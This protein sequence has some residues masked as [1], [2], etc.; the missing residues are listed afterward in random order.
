MALLQD[1]LRV[2]GLTGGA[3]GPSVSSNGK[4]GLS[5]T[6]RPSPVSEVKAVGDG[7]SLCGDLGGGAALGLLEEHLLAAC[8]TDFTWTSK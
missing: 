6:G 4:S 7:T 8:L 3:G 5:S 2:A 1:F